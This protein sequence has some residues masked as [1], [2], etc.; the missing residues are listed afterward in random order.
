MAWQYGQANGGMADSWWGYFQRSALLGLLY[1]PV[2][3][4][5]WLMRAQAVERRRGLLMQ[6]EG[7]AK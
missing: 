4:L 6:D 2:L 1:G 7:A 5:V 3:A